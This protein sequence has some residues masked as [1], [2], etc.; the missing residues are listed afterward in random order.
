MEQLHIIKIGGNVIDDEAALDLFLQKIATISTRK[1]LV[2]GG[3]KLATELARKLGIEQTLIEGRR[4]TDAA[5]LDIAIMVYAGLINKKITAKLQALKCNA[6]GLSGVD[7]N[8]IT[9]TK[10]NQPTIDYGFVG[11]MGNDSINTNQFQFFLENGATPI[12]C[13][14]THNGEGVLLNTNAD[15]IAATIA[16]ALA[17]FYHV[18]LDF[19]F[20]KNGVLIDVENNDSYIMQLNIETYKKHQQNGIISKGMIPK[21]DNA[22]AAKAFGVQQV[23]VCSAVHI[24]NPIIGTIIV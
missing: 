7:A 20:E 10:R 21:L 1:I 2:H 4:I 11:D 24:L 23:R 12:I 18:N 15:T 5:T 22:F 13:P 6:I 19:C 3:G 8:L 9:T 17:Q 16:M 14:I